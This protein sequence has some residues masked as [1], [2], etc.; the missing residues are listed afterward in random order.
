MEPIRAVIGVW[1]RPH[2]KQTYYVL[3]SAGMENYP[4]VW[5][6]PSLQYKKEE[7][8][9]PL[10]CSAARR[11][12]ERMGAERFHGDPIHVYGH[13]ISGSSDENPMERMVE[14]SLYAIAF[15]SE[16]MLNA[17]YYLDGRWMTEREFDLKSVLAPLPCGLCT[18]LWKGYLEERVYEGSL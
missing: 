14:L 1:Y 2:T 15:E 18:K 12:F 7:L 10:D 4:G 5:S 6:L 9:D 8:P 13:L 3:R 17:R 11:I 16:P